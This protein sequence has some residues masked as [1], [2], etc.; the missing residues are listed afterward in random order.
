MQWFGMTLYAKT[1]G[2]RLVFFCVTFPASCRLVCSLTFSSSAA[3]SRVLSRLRKAYS[4][5]NKNYFIDD[6][7]TNK[8]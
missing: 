7:E 5:A 8:L 4:C 1:S 2:S 3:S 6:L